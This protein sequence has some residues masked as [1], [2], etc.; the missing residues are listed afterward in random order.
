MDQFDQYNSP[1]NG[2]SCD[3]DATALFERTLKDYPFEDF[4]KIAEKHSEGKIWVIGG[5]IYRNII[6]EL[7]ETPYEK[8]PIDIDFLVESHTEKPIRQR[9]WKHRITNT[10]DLSFTKGNKYRIDLNSLVNFHSISSNN[11]PPEIQYFYEFNPLNIQAISYDCYEKIVEGEAAIDSIKNK[12]VAVNNSVEAQ[13]EAKRIS[14]KL[15]IDLSVN[16]LIRQKA[17]EIN[18]NY[19][20]TPGLD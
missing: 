20:L 13:W 1:R 17:E 10:G 7:Y 8:R 6:K 2:N 12:L 16:D 14:D 4:L 9:G 15:G 3:F 18:F 19:R 11:L 5:F